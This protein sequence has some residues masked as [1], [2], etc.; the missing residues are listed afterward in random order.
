MGFAVYKLDNYRWGGY[1]VPTIC[2]HPD[3]TEEISRGMANACG[4]EPFS[5]IGCDLYFCSKHLFMC[6]KN[7]EGERRYIQLCERCSKYKTPFPY[8]YELKEWLDWLLNDKSWEEWRKLNPQKVKVI[9][10]KI[11]NKEYIELLK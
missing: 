8:K 1:A 2:E 9:K 3:C 7:I 5:D 4:G 10:E 11:K 6:R